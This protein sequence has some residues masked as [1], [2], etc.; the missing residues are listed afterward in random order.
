MRCDFVVALAQAPLTPGSAAPQVLTAGTTA[1]TTSLRG[2]KSTYSCNYKHGPWALLLAK[3]LQQL[4]S[5]CIFF[6]VLVLLFAAFLAL[7]QGLHRGRCCA[8]GGQE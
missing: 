3:R 8:G 1:S 5:H 4:F 2:E 7:G 6:P